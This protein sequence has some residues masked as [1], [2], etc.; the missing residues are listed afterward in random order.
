MDVVVVG[1]AVAGIGRV[2]IC[3]M[4]HDALFKKSVVY[5]NSRE[6]VEIYVALMR[7]FT[8]NFL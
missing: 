3:G 7:E 8:K 5:T 2:G 1:I 6:I 4:V